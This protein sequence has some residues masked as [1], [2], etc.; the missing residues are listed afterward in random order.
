[1]CLAIPAKVVKLREDGLAD[2]ELDGVVKDV[3][4]DLVDGVDVGDFV[5]VHVGYALSKLDPAEAE[6]T[7]AL[8]AEMGATA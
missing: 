4:L 6:R 7:L 3:S 1:M 8:F 2:V 5:I